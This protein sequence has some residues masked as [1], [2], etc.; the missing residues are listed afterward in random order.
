MLRLIHHLY[1]FLYTLGLLLYFPFYLIRVLFGQK[2]SIPILI[3]GGFLP[4]KLIEITSKKGC[5]VW[6]HA[7]SVGEV[8]SIRTLVESL[9][10]PSDCLYISTTTQTGQTVAQE[11]FGGKA[12]VF[13][14]PLDWAF[15]C[16]RYLRSIDPD[17]II[18]TETELWPS[19]IRCVKK[20]EIPLLLIN[21]RFSDQSFKRYRQFGFLTRSMLTSFCKLGMQS[22]QDRERAINL[23]SISDRTHTVGNLKFDYSLPDNFQATQAS[24][25]LG[26]LLGK[27][28]GSLIWVCGSTHEGEEETLLNVFLELRKEFDQLRWVLAPRHPHR[29]K[30]VTKLLNKTPLTVVR[31]S[32]MDSVSSASPHIAVIDTIGEL[33][34]LYEI[35]DVV[36]IGGTLIPVG[37]HN[38]IEA[39]HFKKPIIFGPHMENFREMKEVFLRSYGALQIHS[40]LELETKMKDLLRD[41][42]TREWLGR[43]ARTVVRENKGAIRRTLKLIRVCAPEIVN[44]QNE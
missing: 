3:R 7:V 2:E 24:Q 17:L 40:S 26:M 12:T 1:S 11:H 6:I 18:L 4:K 37:G 15:S 35:A 31:R 19:F 27:E 30:S 20:R 8:N 33:A 5:R 36:F 9:A 28:N 34:H 42:S 29:A 39:A 38:L 43:N 16:L 23:G 41:T 10:L 32:Q 25:D 22:R 14:F 21:G 13:F 44:S